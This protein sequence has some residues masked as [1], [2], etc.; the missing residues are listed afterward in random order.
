MYI[1]EQFILPDSIIDKHEGQDPM[2]PFGKFLMYRTYSL[3]K[4]NGYMENWHDIVRRIVEGTFSIRKSHYINN[5]IDWDDVKWYPFVKRFIDSLFNLHWS[6]PGRGMFKMGTDFVKERGSMALNNCAFCEIKLN[7][8]MG[9]DFGWFMDALML[10]VGV[11]FQAKSMPDAF[12]I[13]EPKLAVEKYYI[14]D[15]REGWWFSTRDLIKAFTVPGRTKPNFDYSV[16]RSKG[17]PIRGF[18]GK[19]SGPGPLIELHSA[20]IEV[21]R[22]FRNGHIDTTELVADIGNLIGICVVSGNVRRSA[23]IYMGSIHDDTFLELKRKTE[24]RRWAGLSNNT[25]CLEFDGDFDKLSEI[26]NR[27]IQRGEPGLCNLRN[28]VYGRLNGKSDTRPDKARGLNPCGEITLEDKELCCLA[29]TYPMN[30]TDEE[31]NLSDE[32]WLEACEM[33]AFYA[34]TCQLLP[35]H[36]SETNR[37]IARNRRIGVGIAGFTDWTTR[38]PMHRIIPLLKRGYDLIRTVSRSM[39]DEAG[40][41]EPIKITTIKPGGTTPPVCTRND[42]EYDVQTA[43]CGY[44]TFEYTGQRVT[45]AVNSPLVP[46]LEE[47]KIPFEPAVLD[48]VNTRLYVYPVRRGPAKPSKLTNIWEQISNIEVLQRYWADNAVS[49]TIYFKPKWRLEEVIF[50]PSFSSNE[51]LEKYQNDLSTRLKKAK[52]VKVKITKFDGTE[53]EVEWHN[54][55]LREVEQVQVFHFDPN[56]E[57]DEL[58]HM[59]SSKIAHLKSISLLPMTGPGV[60]PQIPQFEITK[61]EYLKRKRAIEDVDYSKLLDTDFAQINDESAEKWCAGAECT[62]VIPKPIDIE[63]IFEKFNEQL[64][65]DLTNQSND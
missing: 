28:F 9:D 7:H 51:L 26:T 38:K 42:S 3:P 10:G 24:R 52:R 17:Q 8:N 56:H 32:S 49:N 13:Y 41:P 44:P 16:V 12:T 46:L 14:L 34:N 43:G 1:T 4:T 55:D 27:V 40:V 15:S 21:F 53:Y 54:F 48:P 20:I 62:V 65:M 5:R 39:A 45:V 57:E 47:A 22:R 50:V 36:W 59:L 30:C 64:G 2:T 58:E 19:A 29:E 11:G 31:G 33:A 18:G 60:Y 23:E 6:P 35:T 25:C 63:I 61:T 37:V